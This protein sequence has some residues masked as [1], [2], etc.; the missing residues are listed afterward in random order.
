MNII[1]THGLSRNYGQTEALRDL[2][3]SVPR[4]SI[5]GLLGSNGA[6]KTTTIR[7]ILN[8][9]SPTLGDAQVMGVDSR[10]L[11]PMQFEKIG[12]VSEGLQ[13]PRWMTIRAYLDYCRPFYPSWDRSLEAQLL[14]R[15]ELPEGRRLGVLSR[16]MLMK[17][18]LTSVLSFRPKL[19]VLDEPFS[20]LDPLVREE[21]T[22]GL[23]EV[24]VQGD[25]TVLVSSHDIEEVERLVDHVALLD[26]GELRLSESAD[27]ILGRFRRVEVTNCH[28]SAQ[29]GPDMPDWEQVGGLGRF[30]STNY[31]GAE[32]ERQWSERFPNGAFTIR[33]LTLREVFIFVVKQG[34]K[35]RKDSK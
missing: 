19:L 15:F 8:R 1:E 7:L 31:D 12:Y 11:R 5:F 10:S 4:G 17:A 2:N 28:S 30:T 9:L 22:R 16:G 32:T 20:G 34:R 13:L 25:W 6:G 3:I 23:L 29:P 14:S 33:P 21:F 18:M 27:A 24:S 35:G 26:D